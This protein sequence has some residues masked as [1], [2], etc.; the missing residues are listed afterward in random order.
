MTVLDLR[1]VLRQ[2]D[3]SFNVR[4]KDFVLAYDIYAPCAPKCEENKKKIDEQLQAAKQGDWTEI[5]NQENLLVA[6]TVFD[7]IDGFTSI[8]GDKLHIHLELIGAKT[9]EKVG[10]AYLMYLYHTCFKQHGDKNKC[11]AEIQSI[12]PVELS[13][14]LNELFSA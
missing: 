4:E 14:K 2:I 8:E 10:M 3:V 1:T 13:K 7:R 12:D 9:K 6:V 5:F 11:D